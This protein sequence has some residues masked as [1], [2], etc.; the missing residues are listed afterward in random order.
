MCSSKSFIR[1]K[2]FL[3]RIFDQIIVVAHRLI[4]TA[5]VV[6]RPIQ[7]WVICT[8]KYN[9]IAFINQPLFESN[10]FICFHIFSYL[11][12]NRKLWFISFHTYIHWAVPIMVEFIYFHNC[13]SYYE[14]YVFISFHTSFHIFS[15]LFTKN[16][17]NPLTPRG[18]FLWK[19]MKICEF[20]VLSF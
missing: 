20:T 15:Y 5:S 9:W 12:I 4:N 11:F 2:Q 7:E 19:D 6:T 1:Y 17:Q 14:S 18:N 13:N 8:T 10:F 16:V 3:M